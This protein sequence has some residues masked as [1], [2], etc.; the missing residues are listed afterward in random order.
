MK[1]KSFG[2][3]IALVSTATMAT[4]GL[5]AQVALSQ[6]KG[7]ICDVKDSEITVRIIKVIDDDSVRVANIS[8]GKTFTMF[9][10]NL[11]N[12]RSGS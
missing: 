2:S 1:T 10:D 11:Q 9:A 12:C 5:S 8:T 6:V 7:D 3:W 4:L